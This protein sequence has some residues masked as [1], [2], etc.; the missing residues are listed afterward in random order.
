L[1]E[2]R[3]EFADQLTREDLVEL[4]ETS[5]SIVA[6]RR[7]CLGAIV[8]RETSRGDVDPERAREVLLAAVRA[9]GGISALPWSDN[10]Q[11]MRARLAFVAQHDSSWPSVSDDALDSSLEEWLAP[12]L[13]GV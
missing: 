11:R 10:A 12:H 9:R 8:L 4:D 5:G 13:G 1:E 7:E 6:R 2:I 3:D